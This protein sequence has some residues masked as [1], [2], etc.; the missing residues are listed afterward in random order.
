MSIVIL[1][2][3]YVHDY[4]KCI[5]AYLDCAGDWSNCPVCKLKPKVWE[6]NNGRSTA[7]GCWKNKY[8]HFSIRAESI[9]SVYHRTGSTEEYDSDSLRKNWNHWCETGELLFDPKGDKFLR[10]W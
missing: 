5:D 4:Y 8:D 7:C 9:T 10:M 3:D 2:D 1:S 6:F